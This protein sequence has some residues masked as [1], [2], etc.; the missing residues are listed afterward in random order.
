MPVLPTQRARDYFQGKITNVYVTDWKLK[1]FKISLA[2]PFN[3]SPNHLPRSLMCMNS[4]GGKVDAY[5]RRGGD[6]R[7]LAFS[8]KAAAWKTRMKGIK[9]I[10]IT[11]QR[12]QQKE[13]KE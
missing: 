13:A 12:K 10:L 7:R 11:T 9:V 6:L 8:K 5:G 1:I 2:F 4:G 3:A